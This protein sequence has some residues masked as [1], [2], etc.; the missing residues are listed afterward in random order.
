M[1]NEEIGSK[2]L[3]YLPR[4]QNT[5]EGFLDTKMHIGH[6]AFPQGNHRVGG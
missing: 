5:A 6:A 2:I 4:V 3:S 1:T